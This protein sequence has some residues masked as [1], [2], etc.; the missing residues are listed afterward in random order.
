MSFLGRFERRLEP[1]FVVV[2][3]I[4][5]FYCTIS[6][7]PFVVIGL[8]RL[9]YFLDSE[10]RMAYHLMILAGLSKCDPPC[11]HAQMDYCD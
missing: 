8:L 3:W 1:F 2:P 5:E 9:L 11:H 10:V 7:A 6:N 4:A